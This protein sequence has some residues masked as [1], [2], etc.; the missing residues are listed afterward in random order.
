MTYQILDKGQHSQGTKHKT[1]DTRPV[2]AGDIESIRCQS[3]IK[4]VNFNQSNFNSNFLEVKFNQSISF[5]I[6]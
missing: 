1:I 3:I 5:R 4:L 6:F 2:H